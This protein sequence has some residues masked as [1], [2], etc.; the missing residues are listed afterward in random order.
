MSVECGLARRRS[1]SRRKHRPAWFSAFKQARIE[2]EWPRTTDSDLRELGMLGVEQIILFVVN[3]PAWNSQ[4]WR[5]ALAD[6]G[7]AK[8][9]GEPQV[10]EGVPIL[11]QASAFHMQHESCGEVHRYGNV[12]L[13]CAFVVNVGQ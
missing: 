10:L 12:V 13:K 2:P 3:D 5:G 7:I 4:H 11:G 9:L 1:T 6:P 8:F